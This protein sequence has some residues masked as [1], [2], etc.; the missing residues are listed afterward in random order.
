MGQVLIYPGLGGDMSRGSYVSQ[1]KAPGLATSDVQYYRDIYKGG[2]SKFAEPLRETDFRGLPPAFMVA[3]G[4]DPLHDDCEDYAA[5][6]R[7]AGV[8]A[9]VRHEPLLVHAFIRARHMS[10]PARDSFRAIIEA[11]FALAYRGA[12]PDDEETF[13][14]PRSA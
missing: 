14:L 5:R 9:L 12:L 4:L 7:A 8:A 13:G 11:V 1:A 6:L 10:E 3:A 2:S